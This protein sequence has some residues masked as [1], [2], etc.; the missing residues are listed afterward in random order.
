MPQGDARGGVMTRISS[1][2]D[3]LGTLTHV[4]LL[5]GQARDLREAAILEGL[6]RGQCRAGGA[7]EADWVRAARIDQRIV[8]AISSRSAR[9]F[10]AGR[11]RDPCNWRPPNGA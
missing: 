4:R 6:T 5:P 9:R 3:A 2:A 11:N 10:P 8:G 1:V 7:F